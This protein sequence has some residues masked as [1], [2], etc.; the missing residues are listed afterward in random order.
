MFLTSEHKRPA[1]KQT[2]RLPQWN[3]FRPVPAALRDLHQAGRIVVGTQ[4]ALRMH[5]GV[6]SKVVSSH[7]AGETTDDADEKSKAS[8]NGGCL[9]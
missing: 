1:T 6:Q 7:L 2:S 3:A 4:A 8:L 5:G 9:K